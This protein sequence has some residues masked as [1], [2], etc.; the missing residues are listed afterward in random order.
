MEIKNE[1]GK[2]VVSGIV[3]NVDDCTQIS[4]AMKEVAKNSGNSV[5]VEFLDSFVIP[6]TLIG[7]ILKMIQVDNMTI[8]VKANSDL[9]ELLDRLSL[10]SVFNVS[11]I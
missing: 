3:E 5:A 9:Y 1:Y 4:S 10:V 7:Q 2:V 6:S 8:R 11:R